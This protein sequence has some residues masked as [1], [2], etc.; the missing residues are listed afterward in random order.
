VVSR[1]FYYMRT[2]VVTES[3]ILH[4]GLVWSGLAG[5]CPME[6]GRF[7]LLIIMIRHRD[8]W[9]GTTSTYMSL[10]MHFLD[11]MSNGHR[12]FSLRI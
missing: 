1:M 6:Q 2:Q 12:Y 3:H 7:S 10:Q 4:Q 8:G 9:K 5:I 11:N